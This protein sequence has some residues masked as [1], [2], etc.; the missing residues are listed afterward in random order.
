MVVMGMQGPHQWK[1]DVYVYINCEIVTFCNGFFLMDAQDVTATMQRCT[2][3][4]ALASNLHMHCSPG[5][6]NMCRAALQLGAH[7]ICHAA[8]NRVRAIKHRLY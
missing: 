5:R 7:D 4:Q 6:N 2:A 3:I 8:A 1:A